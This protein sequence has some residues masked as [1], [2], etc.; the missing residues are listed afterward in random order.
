MF[1]ESFYFQRHRILSSSAGANW[2]SW[3]PTE[4]ESLQKV[5]TQALIHEITIQ[6]FEVASTVV[7]WFLKNMPAAYFRQTEPDLR[8]HHL[9]AI[10]AIKDLKDSNLSLKMDTKNVLNEI[11][12]T[13]Y[14]ASD[15]SS[16][17][18]LSTQ[19]SSL[20]IPS[21]SYL[22]QVKV[23]SSLDNDLALNIFSFQKISEIN[24][25]PAT[26]DDA[27]QIFELMEGIMLGQ[28]AHDTSY[29][30]AIENNLLTKEKLLEYLTRVSSVY[31]QSTQPRQFLQQYSLFHQ[32]KGS[33][34]VA[35]EVQSFNTWTSLKTEVSEAGMSTNSS[36]SG[37][38]NT[39]AW[40]TIA[41][42]NVIPDDLL[43]QSSMILAARNLDI[44][45]AQLDI[46][47][48]ETSLV[49][50]VPHSGH[51]SMI[52]LLVSLDP[53][54]HSTQFIAQLKSDFKRLKWLDDETLKLGL[55][56]HPQLG[57]QKA[58]VITAICSM[59]HGPLSKMNN[60][61]YAS[62]TSI[63][64]IL[65]F[66]PHFIQL[67][68]N[69]VTLFL[70]R[71]KPVKDDDQ[72]GSDKSKNEQ[73]SSPL[74]SQQPCR[75]ALSE[76]EYQNTY[77]DLSFKIGRLH[78]EPARNL[79]LKM[80]ETVACT[81]RT[82]FYNE[83]RYALSLR[84]NPII[85]VNSTTTPST[86]V[87]RTH[88]HQA[89]VPFGVFFSH[90]RYFNGFHCRFRDIARGGL[91]I[92]TPSNSDQY[93]L[94]SARQFDEAYGLSFAQQLK[95]KDIPEGGAKAVVL[96]N[97]SAL[98]PSKRFF[99]ARTSV[100]AFTDS[101]LD[102]IVRPSLS[103]LVDYYGKD[104]LVYLGPDEQVIP[105]DIDWIINRATQ[106]E[107]PIPAA[108]MSS[109]AG[110]GINHKQYG[111]TSEGINVYLDVALR[112]TLNIDPRKDSFTIKITGGPDGDVAGNLIK[113]MIRDYGRNCR[114]VGIADGFGVAEDPIGLDHDELLR[115]VELSQP[116][117]AF[118]TSKLSPEG[119]CMDISTEE[120]LA[121]RLSLP[122]RVKAD[123]FVPAGGRPN[124]INGENW[125]NYLV[126]TSDTT[127]TATAADHHHH[128][129]K[130][131]SPLIVEG[132]NIFNTPEARENLF[133]HAGV[134][135]VKDS[136]ANKCGVIT[137]SCEVAA[138]M[139]L[140]NSEFMSIK[141]ELVN[142]VLERLRVLAR[143][144]AE[145]LFK[146]YK[147]FPG[148]LPHFSERISLAIGKVKDAIIISLEQVNPEDPLFQELFP[149]IKEGL[150]RKLAEVA[151]DRVPVRLPVQYQRC[152]I[153]SALASKLVYQ[154]GIHIIEAQPVAK[155][156]EN[157][158]KY[159]REDV[160]INKLVDELSQVFDQSLDTVDTKT[161][162]KNEA[163][164]SQDKKKIVEIIKRGGARTSLGIF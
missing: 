1:Y 160:K 28:Y 49:S 70:Q 102:L 104:E 55:I 94:E 71:F 45:R 121:R 137:S 38:N 114:V 89:V 122:F 162:G 148:A 91:R 15:A 30:Y 144:E 12:N 118:N 112:N 48:D 4:T 132:A 150:P 78:H 40:I 47:Q 107:Y 128:S 146:L 125:K 158:I 164:T 142:D 149:L 69:I 131:S 75:S 53:S 97:A 46:V 159:Y 123:A 86:G 27:K 5:T 163:L 116:I 143:L 109:K 31:V 136:S 88:N 62:I 37:S 147:N 34:S 82:N 44:N 140:T 19:M 22:S 81:L 103:Q 43:K 127:S 23:F 152:A 110:A 106:R 66:S 129:N 85:M 68:D 96:V 100:K 154:E 151:W 56:R 111:V 113:I 18:L 155:L 3:I 153:A 29:D 133:K 108:F 101:I 14:I 33:D 64:N 2:K 95:N 54:V 145:L 32:V 117:T 26:S 17:G 7:P 72:S 21:G 120:G 157:A 59:L 67:A 25:V 8:K 65:D 51:V 11:T 10:Q 115:L 105:S 130:P 35:V 156:A 92:V 16:K 57:L 36:S 80:L 76:E 73:S 98:E 42:A 6:N 139:L 90:G 61:A 77:R 126:P 9:K 63:L 124:T 13:T 135:I 50:D 58:E 20:K 134:I 99:A 41:A 119:V 60:E 84:V 161:G 138:S 39:M 83:N 74:P 93:F 87:N 52:R 24:S 79:L 141:E